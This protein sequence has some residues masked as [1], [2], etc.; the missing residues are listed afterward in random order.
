LREL[1]AL[2]ADF[3]GREQEFA[4]ASLRL[5]GEAGRAQAALAQAQSRYDQVWERCA[6][7]NIDIEA[8]GDQAEPER[9]AALDAA[10]LGSQIEQGRQ[11]LRRMGAI[12][13]LAPQEWAETQE[14]HGFLVGQIADVREAAA[15]LRELIAEL[16]LAMTARFTQIFNAVAVEFGQTFG[17]LFG[18]GTAQLVLQS[19]EEG[20]GIEIIAQPP[21]KRRQP[22]SLLSGGERSLT[23]AALLFALLKV[24]PTPFC[25]MDEVDAALDE[26]N[27][28][29]FRELVAELTSQTQFIIVTHNRGTVEVAS[30]LYGV[31]MQPDGSSRVL[32]VQLDELVENDEG[33]VGYVAGE[34]R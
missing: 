6:E 17:R 9:W 7:E 27:V 16:D 11:R 29:R 31:S 3:H 15:M 18:G 5:E 4:A 28:V 20:G 33:G 21:G 1:E 30:T 34:R 19:G 26:A 24:N 22:L 12:N 2:L 14:R 8:I 25:V 23:A 10:A 13:P 32:S